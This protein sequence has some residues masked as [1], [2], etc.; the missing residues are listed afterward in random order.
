MTYHRSWMLRKATSVS[1]LQLRRSEEADPASW[2]RSLCGA[3]RLERLAGELGDGL[4]LPGGDLGGAVADAGGDAEGDARRNCG[5]SR[6]GRAAAAAPDLLDDLRG[7]LLGQPG[8]I[9]QPD[10]I[11]VQ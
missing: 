9:S 10:V 4:A 8:P 1:D 2:G 6:E 7:P 5:L 11:L 3:P